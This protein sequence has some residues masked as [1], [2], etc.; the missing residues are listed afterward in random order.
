[1][2]DPLVTTAALLGGG[3]AATAAGL[4]RQTWAKR[5][6]ANRNGALE[7][8]LD[9]AR[10]HTSA[11]DTETRHL[12]EVRLPALVNT[13]ARGHR[14]ISVPR[15]GIGALKGTPFEEHHEKVLSLCHEAV[16]VTRENIGLAARS[17]VREVYDEAQTHLVR[18]QMKA[19]EEMNKFPE[20][21]AYH[22]SL[23]DLDHMV[24][25][26]L[27]TVQRLRILTGSWPGLQRADCTFREIV[28]S[29]RGRIDPYL[30]VHYIYEPGTGEMWVEGRVVEPVTIALTELLTNATSFSNGKVALEVQRNQTG[31]CIIVDDAGLNMNAQQRNRVTQLLSQATVLDV[32][33]LPDSLHFGFPVIGRLSGDYGFHVDVSSTSPYGGVRAVL[34]V[35]HDLLGTGP[36][37]EEREA[38]RQETLTVLAV[39]A[40][41]Q[42]LPP[43][44]PV[45]DHGTALPRRRRRSPRPATPAAAGTSEQAPQEDPDTFR[46]GLA[47][48]A[49]AIRDSETQYSEGDHPHA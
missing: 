24:T 16:V 20:G 3:F 32:T 28:E 49:G 10:Q 14:G 23:M 7:R 27:H 29:A 25:R 41:A 45:A 34:R 15:L 36:T 1:M 39:P 11:L 42:P 40:L 9:A 17:A 48:L 4:V 46:D 33:N 18:C 31:L 44:E 5:A 37:E 35:P 21:T 38:E 13:A 43:E 26:S 22:Q 12:A 6:L 47:N 2:I 8:D 30:R 19:V